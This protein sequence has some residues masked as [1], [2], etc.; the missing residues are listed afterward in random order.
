MD[1]DAAQVADTVIGGL[2]A[3]GDGAVVLFHTWPATTLESC[4]RW[5]VTSE[6]WGPS[7]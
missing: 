1:R 6:G 5:S 2:K 7:S 4:R 3:H